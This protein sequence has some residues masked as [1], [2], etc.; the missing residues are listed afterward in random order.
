MWPSKR[1]QKDL[2]S[3][4]EWGIYVSSKTNEENGYGLVFTVFIVLGVN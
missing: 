1:E 3:E 2:H 4:Y